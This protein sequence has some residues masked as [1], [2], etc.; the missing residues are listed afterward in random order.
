M[1]GPFDLNELNRIREDEYTILSR[2]FLTYDESG[3]ELEVAIR[4]LKQNANSSVAKRF[5]ETA[6]RMKEIKHPNVVDTIEVSKEFGVILELV[7]NSDSEKD[8]QNL[9]AKLREKPIAPNLVRSVL[10]Q[11]LAALKCLHSSN[12]IHGQINPQNLLFDKQGMIKLS[13]SCGY[14]TEN[15]VT[16]IE[17]NEKYTPPELRGQQPTDGR[18]DL[19]CLGFS[20]CEMLMGNKFG[21]LF[22]SV[23]TADEASKGQAWMRWHGSKQGI[24]KIEQIYSKIPDDLVQVISLMLS[25]SVA[26]RPSSADKALLL[27]DKSDPVPVQ[28]KEA[29]SKSSETPHRDP[30]LSDSHHGSDDF[31]IDD[32]GSDDFGSGDFGSGDFGSG[33]F[34]SDDSSKSPSR[35][36]SEKGNI[37][38]KI[39]R[40]S[41]VPTLLTA[42]LF[43]FGGAV[44]GGVGLFFWKIRP[45][46]EPSVAVE[47]VFAPSDLE[48]V[49]VLMDGKQVTEN[50]AGHWMLE[51]GEHSLQFSSGDY[52]AAKKYKIDDQNKKFAVTLVNESKVSADP[53]EMRFTLDPPDSELAIEDETVDVV[54]GFASKVFQP[55]QKG[56]KISLIVSHAGYEILEKEIELAPQKTLAPISI[57]LSPF[58]N[59]EPS[60][61]KVFLDDKPL[62]RNA[63]GKLALPRFDSSSSVVERVTKYNILVTKEGYEKFQKS[64]LEYKTLRAR[65]YR[66]ELEP[67]FSKLFELGKIAL[68]EKEW[69]TALK[70]FSVVLEHDPEEFL[71]AF[72]YRGSVYQQRAAEGDSGPAIKNF[73]DFLNR[74]GASL[75][76][77]DKAYAFLSRARVNRTEEYFVNAVSDYRESN[78]LQPSSKVR[79]ELV[80]VLMEKGQNC[81]N[82]DDLDCAI[83]DF[84]E[85]CELEKG[86]TESETLLASTLHKRAKKLI[87]EKNNGAAKKD[88]DRC[89][90]LVDDNSTF[91]LTRAKCSKKLGDGESALKDLE[92]AISIAPKQPEAFVFRA[93]LYRTDDF[94]YFDLAIDDYRQALA[95]NYSPEF[96]ILL[97]IGETHHEAGLA[98]GAAKE[99]TKASDKFKLAIKSFDSMKS[100]ARGKSQ[101]DILEAQQTKAHRE[102]ANCYVRA[103]DYE[104]AIEEYSIALGYSRETDLTAFCKRADCYRFRNEFSNA[105][106]DLNKVLKLDPDFALEKGSSLPPAR[107]LK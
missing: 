75:K 105:E 30:Y 26:N 39:A 17:G 15:E 49:Q 103:A 58:L 24:D 16:M 65:E 59:V 81:L 31:G 56:K 99:N 37:E 72:L 47:F 73:T 9:A 63:D 102:L 46:K 34:G 57:A 41:R 87:G 98:K 88:M 5:W 1:S 83:L 104:H 20:A 3:E 53:F 13:D 82:E 61:A 64:N 23:K 70:N 12:L 67:D 100:K 66:I 107:K 95:N 91:Y 33:D 80:E 7:E 19:Y 44:F 18:W 45:P 40:K 85:A 77:Q 74:G 76:I 22:P 52:K 92:N 106:A 21:E 50:S 43:L 29:D 84:E 71:K 8:Q 78:R 28:I 10:R 90:K 32:F 69:E 62:A 4:S 55:N 6:R 51:H 79:V 38:K 14:V 86:F 89:L 54:N 11:S 96:D 35:D 27:L 97:A 101:T 36:D 42:A 2:G 25:K 60:D 93:E 94:A 68:D 48:Q